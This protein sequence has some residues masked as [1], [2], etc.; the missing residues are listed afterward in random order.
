MKAVPLSK[1][2][3]ADIVARTTQSVAILHNLEP[4]ETTGS[5]YEL[6]PNSDRWVFVLAGM[7]QV[8]VNAQTV[9]VREGSLLLIE[10]G[11]PYRLTN[12]GDRPFETLSILA[13]MGRCH[14]TPA[15]D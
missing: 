12:T 4:G 9:G 5:T 15:T 2:R 11:E 3:D 1:L 6:H 13:P 10:A 8:D 14:S 7:G